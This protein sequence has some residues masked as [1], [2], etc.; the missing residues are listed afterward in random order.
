MKQISDETIQKK[1]RCLE[2]VRMRSK[3]FR[4]TV[5]WM[6]L[7]V[8]MIMMFM[9]VPSQN[10]LAQGDAALMGEISVS[11]VPESQ[12]AGGA[13]TIEVGIPF[14]GGCC[15]P[16]WAVDVQASLNV[17]EHVTIIEGPLPSKYDE[18]EAKAGGEADYYYFKWKVKSMIP[19]N[20]NVTAIVTTENCGSTEGVA[21]FTIT[22]GC[23]MS[24]PEV[25]P[26]LAPTN[27]D[28]NLNLKA[29]SPIEGVT[30][31]EVTLFYH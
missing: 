21:G 26:E 9:T 10:A 6:T 27:R 14:Y 11:A 24:I 15:Y 4:F 2:D 1:L 23:V 3:I 5:L 13:I 28:I 22:E 30:I 8:F 20:Y 18:I 29:L 12:G 7:G 17:P 31:E 25:Y 19:G 16:L